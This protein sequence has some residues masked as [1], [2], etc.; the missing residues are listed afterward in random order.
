ML[1]PSVLWC[2]LLGDRKGIQ[3]V[4]TSASKPLRMAVNVNVQSTA[5]STLWVWRVSACP[6][7]MLR[8]RMT[9]DWESRGKPAN[10]GVPGKWPLKRCV[11]VCVWTN[12]T[13]YRC[14][15]FYWSNWEFLKTIKTVFFGPWG[16]SAAFKV[17]WG[18]LTGYAF[19]LRGFWTGL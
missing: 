13:R 7:R 16:V 11:C 9:G 2:C 12:F 6:V 8:M 4:K 18:L 10:S 15:E 5:R 3:P 1:L 17:E 14:R 19:D